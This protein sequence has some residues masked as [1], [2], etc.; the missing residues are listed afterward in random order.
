[1]KLALA[2][3]IGLALWAGL[4]HALARMADCSLADLDGPAGGA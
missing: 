3:L 4:F 1:M 2:L